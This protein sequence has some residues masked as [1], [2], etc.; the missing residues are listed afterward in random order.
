MSQS[1]QLEIYE[2]NSSTKILIHFYSNNFLK[3][4]VKYALI[5]YTCSGAIH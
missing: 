3:C 4:N 5:F 1:V 2:I